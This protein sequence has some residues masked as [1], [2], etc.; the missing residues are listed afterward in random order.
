MCKIKQLGLLLLD[1]TRVS[2]LAR[3]LLL[4]N[5][6]VSVLARILLLDN[7]RVSVLARIL[8][9]GDY[10]YGSRALTKKS[11]PFNYHKLLASHIQHSHFN[12]HDRMAFPPD[13][14]EK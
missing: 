5:T 4:D 2:V 3:I 6:R 12:L 9:T 8:F 1:N 7:T 10:K 11:D 14:Q 13:V